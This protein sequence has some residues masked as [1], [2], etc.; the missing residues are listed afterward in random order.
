MESDPFD[1]I[2]REEWY[3][4]LLRYGLYIGAAFQLCCILAIVVF[5]PS[6][7]DQSDENNS[8]LVRL[9]LRTNPIHL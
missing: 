7:S 5:P 8:A 9:N 4:Q 3:E 1:L 6:T 2:P